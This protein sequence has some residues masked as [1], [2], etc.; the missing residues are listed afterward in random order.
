M[1]R[2]CHVVPVLFLVFSKLRGKIDP[3]QVLH[4][5][6]PL[7]GTFFACPHSRTSGPGIYLDNAR[8]IGFALSETNR[9]AISMLRTGEIRTKKEGSQA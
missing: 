5:K 8:T 9:E 1:C 6:F 2:V 7:T 3:G 4:A